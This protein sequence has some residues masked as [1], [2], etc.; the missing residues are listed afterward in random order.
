MN[1]KS[2]LGSNLP[3]ISAEQ[4]EHWYT[5]SLPSSSMRGTLYPSPSR[6]RGAQ[7]GQATLDMW[8]PISDPDSHRSHLIRGGQKVVRDR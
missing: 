1:V 8:E 7:V 6:F 5:W 4:F 2:S 3:S